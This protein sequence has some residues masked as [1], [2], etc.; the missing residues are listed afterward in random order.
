M[1]VKTLAKKLPDTYFELVQ[2]FPLT[3][4]RDEDH[5]DT[6]Q[7]VIDDLLQRDL[8]KAEQEYLDALTD[9]VETHE[10]ENELFAHASEA[11]VLRELMTSNDLS[12]Q[13]LAKES[14]ISQSTISAVLNGARSLTK[15]Q[16]IAL[17]SYFRVAPGAFL[18]AVRAKTAHA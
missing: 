8:D 12:Q 16:V 1:A 11:G 9:L 17:A 6:A 2:V 4:I 10:D 5:L 7:R 14:R 18:P 15:N 3:H 13:K